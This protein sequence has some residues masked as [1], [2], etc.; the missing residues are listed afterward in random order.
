MLVE[1]ITQEAKSTITDWLLVVAV[2]KATS[3]ATK[4][5]S[6]TLPCRHWLAAFIMPV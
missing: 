1:S 3:P 4:F 6:L 2:T 5:L